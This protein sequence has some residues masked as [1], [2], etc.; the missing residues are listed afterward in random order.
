MIST[1]L[2]ACTVVLGCAA[3]DS[4]APEEPEPL[5]SSAASAPSP[6]EEPQSNAGF[7][8][9]AVRQC[10][11]GPTV[12]GADVSY[13][14]GTIDWP[15]AASGGLVFAF[16]RVAD[17]TT[18]VDNQV[19]HNWAGMKSAGVIRGAYQFFRPAQDPAAQADTFIAEMQ[20]N[21]GISSGDLPPALDIEVMDG[22][23]PR[24]VLARMQTWL[25]RVEIAFGKRPVIYASPGFWEA[26]DAGPSFGRYPL[27]L[28]HWGSRC[29]AKPDTWARW[30]F[31]QST[32]EGTIPGIEGPVDLDRF[33][34]SRAD[35]LAF[36]AT[37]SPQRVEPPR[38]TELPK[39]PAL[40]RKPALPAPTRRRA[41]S[42]LREVLAAAISASPLRL[43]R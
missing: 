7:E 19:A 24:A 32:D 38:R 37:G 6:L 8:E 4:T 31:W 29:P 36:A 27:W 18:V 10:A 11:L 12:K 23:A 39:K 9:D 33:N 25:D 17:G 14:Q 41:S 43:P 26:L 30:S 16:A 28:A 42:V 3:P 21:G 5:L 22:V 13:Y 34:G 35:L 2:L 15:A 20:K 1:A 40:P